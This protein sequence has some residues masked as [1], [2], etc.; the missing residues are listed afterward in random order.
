MKMVDNYYLLIYN[1]YKEVSKMRTKGKKI[2]IIGAGYVGSTTAYAL[3]I[4]GIASEIVIVDVNREKAEGEAMD[5]S[6]GATFVKPVEIRAGEYEDTKDSDIVI[7]TAGVQ[8]KVGESRLSV[9]YKNLAV[10]QKI[11]PNI[12]KYSPKSILLVVSNPVDILTYIT[13]KLSGFPKERVIGSGTVL[14]TSRLRSM[15][16]AHFQ[17][18][19]RNVHTYIMGE[20]GDSEIASWSITN[21]AGMNIEEYCSRNNQSCE[22]TLKNRLHEEVRKA[23]Y[24]VIQ[25][26]G[27]TY[28]AVALAITK[29]VETILRDEKS[30]LTVSTLLEGKY[31]IEDVYIGVPAIV[32]ASGVE[33]VIEVPLNGE[34]LRQLQESAVVLKEVLKTAK[35]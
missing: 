3:M 13:Y 22:L 33:K 15:L 7:I 2:S 30:I 26:K 35:L 11:I 19:A 4:A 16:S 28:Y 34:E 24:E 25:R 29:I 17:I 10:F 14:D 31:G 8:T 21:I 12:V 20:H 5:L 9:I 23:A 6:H 32:G 1:I 27:A 18:D